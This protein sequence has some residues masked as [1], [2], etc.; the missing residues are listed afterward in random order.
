MVTPY[1][2]IK[3]YQKLDTHTMNNTLHNTKPTFIARLALLYVKKL[4][5]FHNVS[6][7][8]DIKMQNQTICTL[9]FLLLTIYSFWWYIRTLCF[10]QWELIKFM[11]AI[12]NSQRMKTLQI[13][14]SLLCWWKHI[15][16]NVHKNVHFTKLWCATIYAAVIV[17]LNYIQNHLM[18]VVSSQRM[19]CYW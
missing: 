18:I 7:T 2:H 16:N 11:F 1:L 13:Y 10:N 19:K 15:F 17:E 4:L 6:Q 9:C 12:Q 14:L 5:N 3:I 8:K